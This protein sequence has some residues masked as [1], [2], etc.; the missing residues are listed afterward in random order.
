ML[1]ERDVSFQFILHICKPPNIADGPSAPSGL[2]RSRNE[3]IL[4]TNRKNAGGDAKF[5]RCDRG[6][7]FR[8]ATRLQDEKR[9]SVDTLLSEMQTVDPLKA[10]L[11]ALIMFVDPRRKRIPSNGGRPD[12]NT[13]YERFLLSRQISPINIDALDGT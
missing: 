11:G 1:G 3:A 8:S 9:V 6:I 10:Q 13:G 12:K 4:Q 7:D 5:P 2:K